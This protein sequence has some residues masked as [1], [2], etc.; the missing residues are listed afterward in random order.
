MAA[1]ENDSGLASSFT[2]LTTSLMVIFILLLCA[3]LNNVQMAS[4]ATTGSILEKLSEELREFR[5]DGVVVQR[6]P[7]DPLGLLILVPQ[8]LLAFDTNKTVIPL[9]GEAFLQSFIPKLSKILCLP[10]FVEEI[11]SVVVEGHADSRGPE[12]HNLEL[13]QGRSM[14][15]V[16][17]SL[18]ILRSPERER[19][20]SFLLRFLSASGRGKAEPWLDTSGQENQSL[21]RRVIFKI[22]VRSLEQKDIKEVL[23]VRN[24]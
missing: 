9:E 15:V 11:N 22:R 4:K 7:K 5:A 2:D 18:N 10:K 20:R 19:E 16:L 21:S 3:S 8:G 1:A 17:A 6:D 14:A 24:Q 12:E 23:G 13:S